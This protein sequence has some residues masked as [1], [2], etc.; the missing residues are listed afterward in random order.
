MFA[1]PQS[2][3]VN[4]VAISLPRTSM[5]ATENIYTSADG[6]TTMTL[7]QNSTAGRFRREVRISQKKVAEDPISTLNKE[8][9]VSVYLVIDEPK[10][11]FNDTEIGYLVAALEAWIDSTSTGKLLTGEF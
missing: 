7:K 8:I 1:D 3:T 10:W 2:V 6:L 4:A 9:G 11:G 5:R